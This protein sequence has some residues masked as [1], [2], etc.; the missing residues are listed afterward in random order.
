LGV[1]EIH[2]SPRTTWVMAI[3]WSSTTLAR[4]YV[5]K[6]SAFTITWSSGRGALTSPRITSSNTS[7]TS[8]GMSIRTTG[9]SLNPGIDARASRLMP[10]QS[11]S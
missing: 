1:E 4:W 2:S 9:C 6:P 8:S 10:W 11:R 7:G 3:S 5:G